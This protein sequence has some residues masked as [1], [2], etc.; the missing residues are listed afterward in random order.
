MPMPAKP[1]P[2]GTRIGRL[3]VISEDVAGDR[4]RQIRVRC[5]C[6][7]ERLVKKM[8]VTGARPTLSCGH[9]DMGH[10]LRKPLSEAH[11][12]AIAAGKARRRGRLAFY[13]HLPDAEDGL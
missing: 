12:A 13:A 7:A 10:R 5:D 4:Y 11:V 8:N 9:C 6:G 3:T 1:L 2:I